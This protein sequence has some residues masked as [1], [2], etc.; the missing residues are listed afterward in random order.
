[1]TLTQFL[2]F[3]G[4]WILTK[5]EYRVLGII[6]AF[7]LLGFCFWR[8]LRYKLW[9]THEDY[10]QLAVGLIGTIGGLSAAIVFLFTRPPAVDL[11]PGTTILL[12]GL[13]MPIIIIGNAYS[14]LKALFFPPQAPKPPDKL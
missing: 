12:L 6:I 14:R 9:P 11:L 4:R 5:C 3:V 8:R 1:M 10:Y 7:I 13:G 2:D